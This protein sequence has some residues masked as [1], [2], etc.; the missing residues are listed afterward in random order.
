MTKLYD[1]IIVGAGSAGCA[2]ANRLSED[3]QRNVLLLEAGGKDRNPLI[4][5]PLGFAFTMKHPTLSWGYVSDPEPHMNGRRIDQPRGKVLGGSSSINGMVYIR[6]QRE[7]Y[8]HWAELGN[9]EWSYEKLL[10]IFKRC[11][12]YVGQSG[13][14]Y[15]GRDGQLWVDDVQNRYDMAELYVKAAQEA[16]IPFNPDFNGERQEGVGFY[17]VNIRRGRRQSTAKTYLRNAAKRAN[18]HIQ[19][20]AIAT[21][22]LF[23]GHR[24]CG[25]RYLQNGKEVTVRCRG[26]IILCGGTINSPQL[27][28]LSGIGNAEMLSQKGI[29]PLKNLPGVGEN[30]Q[31]HLTVNTQRSF[32]G[33]RTYYEDSRPLAMLNTLMKLIFKGSGMLSHP[34]AQVGVFFRTSDDVAR[35]DAQIHFTPAA[36]DQDEN[37]RMLTVPGTTATVCYLRPKSRGHVHIRSADPRE[38]PAFVHN[39]LAEEEDRRAIIAAVRKTRA[40]FEAP[41][42]EPW[43]REELI[44]GADVQSDEDILEFVRNTGE[45]VYHPVGTCK[46][47]D[48]EMAVVDQHL[49]VH[50][51]EGL[52]VADASVMPTIISGNTNATAVLIG[53]RCADFILSGK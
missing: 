33:V 16:G 20:H 8:D 9:T 27:L 12:G 4:H 42:L 48:D 19:T 6:G 23:E 13:D 22:V 46:M 40:I 25:L 52:R 32:E 39:Y 31:D 41:V 36:G 53:E 34:A 35:P 47:G 5:I 3:G 7:D 29:K 10:P 17:Q 44:P 51:L 30:M 45:S 37:G 50:G 26:E 28:E 2:L 18:L 11:E 1:Y 24:S 38:A 21:Q 43:R 15:H 14:D 49:K